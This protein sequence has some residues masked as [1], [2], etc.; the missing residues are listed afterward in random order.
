MAALEEKSRQRNKRDRIKKSILGSI[1]LVGLLPVAAL[2]PQVMGSLIK[3]GLIEREKFR[4]TRIDRSLRNLIKDG[5]V[6]FRKGAKGKKYLAMTKRGERY[7]NR[8]EIADF[9]IKKPKR[10]DGKWRVIIFDIQEKKRRSRDQLRQTL[11]R[12]GFVKL[13]QS[14][15]IY[16][17]DCEYLI[18]LLKADLELGRN[19][20][21]LIVEEMENDK[22]L[23]FR[24]GL[25][26]A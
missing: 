3:S 18:T 5:L 4:A 6:E 2:A 25:H 26:S 16:P 15:W 19:L 14:V 13:Q 10:W 8:L 12:I 7:L 21:Y 17:Y 23:R 1:A 24:F 11:Q 22:M 9:K 20:L